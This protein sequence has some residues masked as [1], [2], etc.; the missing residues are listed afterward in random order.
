VDD[1]ATNRMIVRETLASWGAKT[2]EATGGEEGLAM[3]HRACEAGKPFRLVIL[4]YQ[5]PDLDGF[6]T[7]RLIRVQPELR[8]T[9]MI[10]LTSLPGKDDIEKTRNIGFAHILY[11]PVKRAELREAVTRA[12]GESEP[13]G[14]DKQPS[15]MIAAP[16]APPQ[17]ALRI[18]LAEDNEDNR[19]LVWM[20]LKNTPHDMEMAE[21]GRLAVDMFINGGSFDIVFMDIQMPIMDGYEATRTIR[22]WEGAQGRK[23]TPIIAL[24]AHAL[25]EDLRK[26]LDAGCDAHLTKPLKKQYSWRP[27]TGTPQKKGRPDDKDH[28]PRHPNP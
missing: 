28:P 17:R 5:M 26:S 1:N 18:L 16:I 25:K 11:K 13:G 21:N 23:R 3:L 22:S 15:P 24:T 10:L 6:E 2:A 7:A 9:L 12:L 4:D 14:E 20:Y 19:T 27:S 8:E